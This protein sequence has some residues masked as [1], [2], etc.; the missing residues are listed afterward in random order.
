LKNILTLEI[1]NKPMDSKI[2]SIGSYNVLLVIIIINIIDLIG[3]R[4]KLLLNYL[5]NSNTNFSTVGR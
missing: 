5:V 1:K 4:C 2:S 3:S